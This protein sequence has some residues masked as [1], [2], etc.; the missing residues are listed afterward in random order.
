MKVL[1]N[2]HNYVMDIKQIDFIPKGR[3]DIWRIAM[4]SRQV[5]VPY[6]KNSLTKITTG[7]KFTQ[8]LV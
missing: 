3:S 6:L 7:V 4:N 2:T 8:A 1:L 5:L